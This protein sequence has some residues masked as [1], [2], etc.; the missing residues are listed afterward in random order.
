MSN[1]K[2]LTT[3]PLWAKQTSKDCIQ[4]QCAFNRSKI[5]IKKNKINSWNIQTS[6]VGFYSYR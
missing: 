5:K 6:N 4:C 2:N 1:A 3:Q